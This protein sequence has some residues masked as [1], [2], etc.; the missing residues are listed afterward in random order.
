MTPL[1]ANQMWTLRNDWFG[2]SDAID[3]LICL[4]DRLAIKKIGAYELTGWYYCSL[5]CS[6]SHL[7][8]QREY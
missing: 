1:P 8:N 4:I 2:L 6:V 7:D 3:C 5:N